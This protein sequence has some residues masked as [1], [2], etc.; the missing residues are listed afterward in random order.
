MV[1]GNTR[2]NWL[3]L[4]VAFIAVVI[5]AGNVFAQATPPSAQAKAVGE[6][7]SIE[8]Q[9]LVLAT[10]DGKSVRFH[11]RRECGWCGSPR[12]RQI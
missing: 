3:G 9:S 4:A 1:H 2:V 10:D 8:G 5:A 12:G 7:K 11:S 6:I